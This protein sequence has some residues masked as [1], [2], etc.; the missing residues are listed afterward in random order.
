M[1]DGGLLGEIGVRMTKWGRVS[2]HSPVGQGLASS[3][4]TAAALHS[5]STNDKNPLQ[6]AISRAVKVGR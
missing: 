1:Q 6:R 4:G 5:A 2:G 3:K